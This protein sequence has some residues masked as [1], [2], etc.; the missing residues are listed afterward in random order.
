MIDAKK[1]IDGLNA[2]NLGGLL[3]NKPNTL[4]P[5]TPQG[6]LHLATLWKKD[7]T[8]VTAIVIGRS[9]LV[10]KPTAQLLINAGCTVTQAHSAT[11]DLAW[12]TQHA[13]LIIS[14]TGQPGLITNH[15]VQEGACVI[16]AGITKM[17]G[18]IIGDV[19]YTSVV[20]KCSAITPVPGGVG[21]TTIAYLLNNC[22][23][24]ALT[25]S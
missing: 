2:Q 22:Y 1:D 25:Q 7:L 8:G 5:C 20:E 3:Q 15:H 21:P 19:A 14:A 6:I 11:K 17:H 9:I 18:K 13:D 10:G 16:D 4:K 23:L 24:S 12:H